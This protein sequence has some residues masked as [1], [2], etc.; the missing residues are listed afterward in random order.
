V[1]ITQD[2]KIVIRFLD[3]WVHGHFPVCTS[4][5]LGEFRMK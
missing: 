2:H 1:I 3:N 4:T 5:L